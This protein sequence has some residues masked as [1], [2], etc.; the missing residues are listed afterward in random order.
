VTSEKGYD[1]PAIPNGGKG[2][3]RSMR[4]TDPL[5]P[6][7]VTPFIKKRVPSTRN[8]YYAAGIEVVR[9]RAA[10]GVPTSTSD[11]LTACPCYTR[12]DAYA[13]LRMFHNRY[14]KATV[15]VLRKDNIWAVLPLR[16]RGR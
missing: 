15:L 13:C 6:L 16:G 9:N 11:V 10:R 1:S 4:V 5:T 2:D 7:C 8:A 14:S 3:E 12:Q